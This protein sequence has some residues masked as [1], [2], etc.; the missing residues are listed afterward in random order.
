[1]RR[2]MLLGMLIVTFTVSIAPHANAASTH[3]RNYTFTQHAD[4]GFT[5]YWVR[6]TVSWVVKSAGE[7]NALYPCFGT[8]TWTK[9]YGNGT[10]QFDHWLSNVSKSGTF[11]NGVKW[12]SREV[13]AEF[14][15]CWQEFLTICD[16][17]YG[18]NK[19]VI[20]TDGTSSVSGWESRQN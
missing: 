12:R 15:F 16:Y 4:S 3:S 10:Y 6:Q 18:H 8:V 2:A 14:K 19:I 11:A 7:C 20:R 13:T 9:D 5:M 1:M 17:V